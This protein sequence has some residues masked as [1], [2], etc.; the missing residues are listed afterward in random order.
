LA[1]AIYI[2]RDRLTSFRMYTHT[3]HFISSLFP[4]T[5]QYSDGP[6]FYVDEASRVQVFC[7]DNTHAIGIY[8]AGHCPSCKLFHFIRN[9]YSKG[10]EE[11]LR[12]LRHVKSIVVW[13]EGIECLA[14]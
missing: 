9:I 5:F 13:L 14:L 7:C 1:R 2:S 4:I 11:I 12:K 8:N 3:R 10:R 6:I